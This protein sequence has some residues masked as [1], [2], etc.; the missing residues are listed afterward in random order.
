ME[1]TEKLKKEI[2]SKTMYELL[3]A[4]RFENFDNP[5]F[6]GESGDYWLTRI[7]YLRS[8]PGGALEHVKA[9]KSLGW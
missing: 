7:N 1:L 5:I 3:K 2:D 8:Q 9:S 4:V 6:Q